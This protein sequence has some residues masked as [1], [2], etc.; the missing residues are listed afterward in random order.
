MHLRKYSLIYKYL[1]VTLT[2]TMSWSPHINNVTNKAKKLLGLIYRQYSMYL[3]ASSL[4]LLYLSFVRPHLEYASQVWSPHLLK[5]ISLLKR[6][7]K[8]GL[9]V[10][11]KN[12]NCNY[13]ESLN[14][15]SLFDLKTRREYLNLC[16]FYS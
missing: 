1:G 4:L 14:E 6:V 8:F 15:L 2:N 16:L 7:Q 5:D 12:W 9:K 3:P 10:C 13:Q 11:L